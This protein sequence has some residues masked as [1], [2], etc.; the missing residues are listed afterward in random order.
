MIADSLVRGLA[1]AFLIAIAVGTIVAEI[2]W[3]FP[4]MRWGDQRLPAPVNRL[5]NWY[6]AVY[7]LGWVVVPQA[8]FWRMLGEHRRG[9]PAPFSPFICRLGLATS[10]FLGLLMVIGC[11]SLLGLIE[12]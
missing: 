10:A 3:L 4:N 5:L 2:P 7:L 12:P 11:A 9:E 1:A 6:I 8:V